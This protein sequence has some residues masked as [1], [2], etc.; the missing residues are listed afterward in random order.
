MQKQTT[1]LTI[2][3]TPAQDYIIRGTIL[4]LIAAIGYTAANVFLR[5]STDVDPYWVSWV[6]AIPTV[7][8]FG[9]RRS[10]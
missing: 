10:A 7:V 3:P 2:H 4:G 1:S 8:I 6:K 9:A 5:F